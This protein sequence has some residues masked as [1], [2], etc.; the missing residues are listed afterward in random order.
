MMQSPPVYRPYAGVVSPLRRPGLQSSYAA[1][2]KAVHGSQPAPPVY[3]PSGV[4][5]QTP[6][7]PV[8]S[9][10]RILQA[11]SP[12]LWAA[13]QTSPPVYKPAVA[14]TP[15]LRMVGAVHTPARH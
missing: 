1:P 6:P 9:P 10:H 13:R 12:T 5:G 2:D 4:A 3:K 8:F 14:R 7:P 11:K 15:I